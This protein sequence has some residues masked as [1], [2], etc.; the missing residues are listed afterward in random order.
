MPG[1]VTKK[2]EPEALICYNYR[3]KK[4]GGL[5]GLRQPLEVRAMS[6]FSRK[7]EQPESY[8]KENTYPVYL[9]SICTGETL[10]GFRDK[11]TKKFSSVMLVASDADKKEF[12]RRFGLTPEEVKQE[13]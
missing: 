12:L 4:A 7:K 5:H 11:T 13:W 3:N 2:L 9:S 8:D 10:A 6:L 1:Y